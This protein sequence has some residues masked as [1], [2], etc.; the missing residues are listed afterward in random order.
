MNFEKLKLYSILAFHFMNVKNLICETSLA[1]KSKKKK[2]FYRVSISWAI[3]LSILLCDYNKWIQNL[4][5]CYILWKY[6]IN[7]VFPVL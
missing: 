6:L 3:Y 5:P 2:Q 7:W 1:M 4:V